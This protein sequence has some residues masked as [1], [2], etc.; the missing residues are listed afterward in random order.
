MERNGVEAGCAIP[1]NSYLID[2]LCVSLADT[3]R[4]V[5]AFVDDQIAFYVAI[6]RDQLFCT[7]TN[8]TALTW[9][10]GYVQPSCYF[11]QIFFG[12]YTCINDHPAVIW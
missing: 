7:C 10:D 12:L 2:Y 1:P 11:G 5:V 4:E 9:G 3:C 8:A 6:V